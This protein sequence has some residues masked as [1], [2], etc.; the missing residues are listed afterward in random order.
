M[1]DLLERRGCVALVV[2]MG[3]CE[4]PR[5]TKFLPIPSSCVSCGHCCLVRGAMTAGRAV[6]R[7]CVPGYGC[8]RMGLSMDVGSY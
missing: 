8:S 4:A 7:L 6:P 1:L 3:W 2:E 5:G